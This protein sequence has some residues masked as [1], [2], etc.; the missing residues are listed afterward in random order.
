M[1]RIFQC[2]V[3]KGA[4]RKR[5]K[6]EELADEIQYMDALIQ[7]GDTG[8]ILCTVEVQTDET[9]VHTNDAALQT[10]NLLPSTAVCEAEVQ[11]EKSTVIEISVQTD[12]LLDG[13]ASPVQEVEIRQLCEGNN[14]DKFLPLVRKHKGIFMNTKGI[15]ICVYHGCFFN[16]HAFT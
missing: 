15:C 2:Y 12:D 7:T 10:E 8:F 14:D 5:A 1:P 3:P 6:L 4:S 9:I 11:T 13:I 16:L